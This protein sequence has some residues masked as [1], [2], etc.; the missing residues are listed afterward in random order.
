MPFELNKTVVMIG[1]MG[2]GKTAVGGAVARKLD[3]RFTDLD[4]EIE[5]AS[6]LTIAEL[7]EKYGENYFREKETQVLT[8]LLEDPPHI[9]STGGGAY[10]FARN[11]RVIARYGVA[12]WLQA[13]V[14]LLWSRVRNKSTRPLLKTEN[15]LETLKALNE[16]RQPIYA[17]APLQVRSL[18]AYTIDDMARQVITTLAR[19]T[20][21]LPL[22]PTRKVNDHAK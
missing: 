9:L 14:E 2:A 19:H 20:D 12:L 17:M 7:F 22:T 21:I 4:H 10:L 3:V 8:R 15:P 1:M 18:P 13:D 11:R 16:E 5:E 6:N